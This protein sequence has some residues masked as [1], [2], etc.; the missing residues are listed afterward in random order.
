VNGR[1]RGA[2]LGKIVAEHRLLVCVSAIFLSDGFFK[3]LSAAAYRVFL[4]K[5]K[6]MLIAKDGIESANCCKHLQNK[7]RR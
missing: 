1:A 5:H 6:H 3:D 4:E 2:L 7:R